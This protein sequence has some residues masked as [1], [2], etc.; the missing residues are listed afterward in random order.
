MFS[1][2]GCTAPPIATPATNPEGGV[3]IIDRSI[4]GSTNASAMQAQKLKRYVPVRVV[5]RMSAGNAN[6]VSIIQGSLV[7]TPLEAFLVIV[8][9]GL[10][11]FP[12]CLWGLGIA[13]FSKS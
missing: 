8:L 7:Y 12:Y 11:L 10:A 3:E 6:A 9:P 5:M 4:A 13:F 2:V 1:A